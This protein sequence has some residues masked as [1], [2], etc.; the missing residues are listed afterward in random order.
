[1]GSLECR[2]WS[3]RLLQCAFRCHR[4]AGAHTLK[5][6]AVQPQTHTPRGSRHSFVLEPSPFER[7]PGSYMAVFVDISGKTSRL[8]SVSHELQSGEDPLPWIFS[9]FMVSCARS[10]KVLPQHSHAWW[11]LN[12]GRKQCIILWHATFISSG[13]RGGGMYVDSASSVA[14]RHAQRHTGTATYSVCNTPRYKQQQIHPGVWFGLTPRE[15][16][17]QTYW[18]KK[19]I[20][21]HM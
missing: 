6:A 18:L 19:I 2:S 21:A 13:W 16:A 14:H 7:R 17:D 4:H 20:P 1:M 10:L 3:D 8:L 15:A 9:F 12:A 5:R 11:L